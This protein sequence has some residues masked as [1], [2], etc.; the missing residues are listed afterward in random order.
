MVDDSGVVKITSTPHLH[1]VPIRLRTALFWVITQRAVVISYQ[2]WL[3]N[4]PE[5]RSSQ[6]LRGGSLKSLLFDWS[7][8]N[9]RNFL[10][11]L[12]VVVLYHSNNPNFTSIN[13]AFIQSPR[14]IFCAKPRWTPSKSMLS[15]V[16]KF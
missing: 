14:L 4:N 5:E 12:S 10:D 1:C 6:L 7:Y 16:E 2:Y 8:N 9:M 11:T 15:F 3:R 13:D